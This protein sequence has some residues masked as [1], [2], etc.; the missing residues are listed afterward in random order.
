[1]LSHLER[2]CPADTNLV[3]CYSPIKGSQCGAQD[4]GDRRRHGRWSCQTS[5]FR[6]KRTAGKLNQVGPSG[7]ASA[8]VQHGADDGVIGAL[9][10]E[11][12]DD[13]FLRIARRRPAAPYS[14]P[15]ET[16]L[17]ADLAFSGGKAANSSG[18]HA[19]EVV[20]FLSSCAPAYRF[21][22][23]NRPSAQIAV[24]IA[25]SSVMCVSIGLLIS[26]PVAL[27]AAALHSIR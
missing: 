15:P 6:S 8:R 1:M 19:C 23:L 9:L 18:A 20:P 21:S 12:A 5:Q 24:G 22:V 27:P 11:T 4:W 14:S 26:R 16:V 25:I 3:N 7:K 13:V 17:R 2:F 10:F